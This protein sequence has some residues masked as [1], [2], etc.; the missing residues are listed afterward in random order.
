MSTTESVK[1]VELMSFEEALDELDRLTDGLV[2]GGLTL[3]ESV[4][5][6]ERAV[7]L[8]RHCRALL[9]EAREKIDV[10]R[11]DQKKTAEQVLSEEE[12]DF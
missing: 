4:E 1:S 12:V 6:Y 11:E 10:I 2:T 3:R 9:T 8:M 7:A 5:G